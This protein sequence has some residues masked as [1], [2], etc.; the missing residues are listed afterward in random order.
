[1]IKTS[2]TTNIHCPNCDNVVAKI[3]DGD[4]LANLNDKMGREHHNTYDCQVCGN[5]YSVV[6]KD[7]I[8]EL[9]INN[10]PMS[11]RTLD[12]LK[13]YD[14]KKPFYLVVDGYT[15]KYKVGD[16]YKYKIGNLEYYYGEHTCT[17]NFIRTCGISYNGNTDPHG[18]FEFVRSVD[19]DDIVEKLG[20]EYSKISHDGQWW[21][22]NQELLMKIFPELL[23]HV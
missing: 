4:V 6:L 7:G 8:H 17:I 9:E 23:E 13:F 11:K 12:L 21:S 14:S 18:L 1:M 2:I 16:D 22:I 19:V 20:V 10:T 5:D 3:D 15:H